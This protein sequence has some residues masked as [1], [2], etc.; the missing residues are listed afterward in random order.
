MATEVA[1]W[2]VR[3]RPGSALAFGHVG[4]LGG[5][6]W[7]GLPGNPVSTMVCFELFVR[8]ALLRMAG[9]TAVFAPTRPVTLRDDYPARAGLTHFPRARLSRDEGGWTA[10]LTGAQ[11]SAVGTSMAMADALLVVPE[12]WNGARAGDVV[13][14]VVLGG[15]PLRVEAGW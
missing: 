6:P 10:R 15:A 12:A 7:F 2:R 5:I 9:E 8:P 1:F 4:A 11:G 13:T 14:A 3:I